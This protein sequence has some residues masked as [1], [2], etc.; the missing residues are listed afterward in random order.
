MKKILSLNLDDDV[1]RAPKLNANLDRTSVSGA[2]NRALAD[3]YLRRPEPEPDPSVRR[4][5]GSKK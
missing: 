5:N 3:V 2:A 4:P 1:I